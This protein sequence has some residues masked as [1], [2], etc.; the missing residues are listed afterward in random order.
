M[1]CSRCPTVA[2]V[3]NGVFTLPDTDTDTD[4]DKKWVIKNYVEVFILP[5]SVN[6][7]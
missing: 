6:T 4:T 2:Y 1:R 5:G 3:I 7:P